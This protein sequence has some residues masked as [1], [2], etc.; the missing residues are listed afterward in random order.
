MFVNYVS[1]H[2][3]WRSIRR[4]PLSLPFCDDTSKHGPPWRKVAELFCY[5]LKKGFTIIFFGNMVNLLSV[6]SNECIHLHLL[7]KYGSV[8]PQNQDIIALRPLSVTV[9]GIYTYYPLIFLRKSIHDTIE[10]P[11]TPTFLWSFVLQINYSPIIPI[12]W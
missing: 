6:T 7:T 4:L 11:I 10:L 5:N 12:V 2:R 9:R 3:L 8:V 1:G